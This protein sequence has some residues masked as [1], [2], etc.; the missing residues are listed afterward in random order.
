MVSSSRC[1]LAAS[2]GG[3]PA[4]CGDHR[5]LPSIRV[6]LRPMHLS[7]CSPTGDPSKPGTGTTHLFYGGAGAHQELVSD[8]PDQSSTRRNCRFTLIALVLRLLLSATP[9]IFVLPGEAE[10]GSAGVQ[11]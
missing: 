7:L 1:R 9:G 3:T 8:R 5:R 6:G 2:L 10:S 11:P 4:R